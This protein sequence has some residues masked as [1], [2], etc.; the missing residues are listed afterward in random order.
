MTRQELVQAVMEFAEAVN[1]AEEHAELLAVKNRLLEQLK[2]R[3]VELPPS[4]K[5]NPAEDSA[6]L[7]EGQQRT[8]ELLL[9]LHNLTEADRLKS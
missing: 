2:A 5:T 3:G 9:Q 1:L 4:L 6:R 7:E 8:R